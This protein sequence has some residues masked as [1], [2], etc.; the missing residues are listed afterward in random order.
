MYV[1]LAPNFDPVPR[2][3][4]TPSL[5]GPNIAPISLM[6][7]LVRCSRPLSSIGLLAMDGMCLLSV[8]VRSLSLDPTLQ[9]GE[10]PS[11]TIPWQKECIKDLRIESSYYLPD[12]SVNVPFRFTSLSVPPVVVIEGQAFEDERGFFMESFKESAF[13]SFGIDSRFVQDNLSHSR[14][15]VLRGLHYQKKPKAQAKLVVAIRGEIF[16]V[17]V[18]IRK[19]S[20]TYSQWVGEVLSAV[21]HRMLYVP[22]G[23]A[24]GFCVLSDEADVLYKVTEEYSREHERGVVWS[25]SDLGVKWPVKEPI[26]SKR[27]AELP[28][29]RDADNDFRV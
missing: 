17:A 1:S 25:D 16:D 23:F 20:P 18:D 15:G 28:S 12:A 4:T 14:K 22:V 29:L 5:M 7:I 27:D 26:V 13:S 3:S 8:Y 11:T 24:H 21:N 6:P 10:G 19:E 9:P 2:K